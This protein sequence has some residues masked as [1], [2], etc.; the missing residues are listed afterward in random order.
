MARSNPSSVPSPS[1]PTRSRRPV[2]ARECRSSGPC[3]VEL[4]LRARLAP[5]TERGGLS[6]GR[7]AAR[8]DSAAMRAQR[9][10]RAT[11]CTPCGRFAQTGATSKTTKRAARAD[12]CSAL[13]AGH[14][15]R[16]RPPRPAPG[17]RQGGWHAWL[18]AIGFVHCLVRGRE[19]RPQSFQIRDWH[20]P[21][22][23]FAA[24][25]QTTGSGSSICRS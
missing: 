24:S 16:G 19:C 25:A 2:V 22:F 1:H 3:A 12:R 17:A 11:R 4:G 15:P 23:R 7:S 20:R 10:R 13:L 14:R 6:L 9:P 5:G 8:P 21:H 18:A